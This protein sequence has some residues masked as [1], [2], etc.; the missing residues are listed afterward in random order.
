MCFRSCDH[1]N[2][3]KESDE[4]EVITYFLIMMYAKYICNP[5]VLDVGEHKFIYLLNSF[6]PNGSNLD[7]QFAILAC[8]S[9][10]MYILL[11]LLLITFESWGIVLEELS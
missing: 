9:Y 8:N 1:R 5:Q 6:N 11:S 7:N 2:Y 4:F 3:D 10:M